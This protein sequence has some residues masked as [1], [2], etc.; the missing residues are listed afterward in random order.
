VYEEVFGIDG[1]HSPISWASIAEM[2][3]FAAAQGVDDQLWPVYD[4]ELS[5]EIPLA[6]VED[7]C[8]KLRLALEPLEIPTSE[9]WLNRVVGWLREGYTF[10]IMAV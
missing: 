6:D 3:R 10:F 4:I 9:V 7:R 8:A 1:D 2:R 5:S